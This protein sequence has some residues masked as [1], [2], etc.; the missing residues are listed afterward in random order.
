MSRYKHITPMFDTDKERRSKCNRVAIRRLSHRGKTRHTKNH[1]ET[2][3]K[4][5]ISNELSER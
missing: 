5:V 4:I 2:R 3:G 1:V